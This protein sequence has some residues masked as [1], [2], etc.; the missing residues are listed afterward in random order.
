MLIV[1]E[2][3]VSG[4]S[5]LKR[6][7]RLTRHFGVPATVCINKYDI[8]PEMTQIIVDYCVDNRVRVLGKIPYD[9]AF[10][11]AQ[12]RGVSLLEYTEGELSDGIVSIWQNLLQE[13][14]ERIEAAR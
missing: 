9:V 5:D 8:N 7:E 6:V 13:L 10:T 3:T 1:T 14:N 2:P 4:L 11:K 12:I